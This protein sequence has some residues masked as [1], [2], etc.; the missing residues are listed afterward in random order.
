[1]RNAAE[2]VFPFSCHTVFSQSVSRE[3]EMFV[4]KRTQLLE[5][6]VSI[7]TTKLEL[8]RP[9]SLLVMDWSASLFD[10]ALTPETDGFLNDDAMPPWD[11]WITLV[12]AKES[13]GMCCLLSW[14]PNWLSEKVDFA[15]SADAG[16]CFS[17]LVVEAR[18]TRTLGWGRRW[19]D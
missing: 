4:R 12:H 6:E 3:F 9:K 8:R 7:E 16:E 5:D 13:H 19:K 1:M 17:W 18:G 2:S 14:V 11:T 10:G 15:I